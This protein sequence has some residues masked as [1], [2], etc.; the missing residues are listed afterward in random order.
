MQYVLLKTVYHKDRAKYQA[1]YEKRFQGEETVHLPITI[2]ESPAFYCITGELLDIVY[3]I[4]M[5]NTCI[6]QIDAELPPIARDQFISSCLIN[7][8]A[9]TNRIE[10]IHS[11]RKEIG[12]LLEG[13]RG[14]K[15][16]DTLLGL[17]R[18]ALF[19][20]LFGDIHPFYNGNGRV[21]RFISSAQLAQELTPYIC[22]Q[23]S[24]TIKNNTKKYYDSFQF[25]NHPLNKGDLTPFLIMFLKLVKGAAMEIKESLE[26][27]YGDLKHYSLAL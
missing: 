3:D 8:V 22:F 13:I 23:L 4:A 21:N 24:Q 17:I 12:E 18:I 1:L 10:G 5:L 14:T 19:H 26:Q 20:Y 11:S 27:K 6:F 9:M 25:C 16:E 15:N 2:G 7:E